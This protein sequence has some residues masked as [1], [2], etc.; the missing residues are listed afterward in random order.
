MEQTAYVAYLKSELR[1]ERKRGEVYS[2]VTLI[3]SV[4]CVTLVCLLALYSGA[5]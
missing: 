4:T 2:Q 1:K 3:L 5:I